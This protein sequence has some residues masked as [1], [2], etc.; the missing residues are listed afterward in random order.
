MSDGFVIGEIARDS[1]PK[2]NHDTVPIKHR[3]A[4]AKAKGCSMFQVQP[5]STPFTP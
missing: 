5:F 1:S 3:L 4:R 2:K